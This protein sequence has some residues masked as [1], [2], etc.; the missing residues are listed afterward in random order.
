MEGTSREELLEREPDDILDVR[1]ETCPFPALHSQKK[2]MRMPVGTVLEILIDHPPSA[3][4]T[5]PGICAQHNWPYAS[6]KEGDS[7]RIRIRKT[8]R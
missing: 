8:G 5:I 4:E 2:L 7:W 1:G 3:E 6:V